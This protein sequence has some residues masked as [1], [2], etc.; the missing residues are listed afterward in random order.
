MRNYEKL[1]IVPNPWVYHSLKYRAAVF[2]GKGL[3]FQPIRSEK[4]RVY[5]FR[6]VEI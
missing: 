2:S 3:K 1:L 4:A 6:L 5:R